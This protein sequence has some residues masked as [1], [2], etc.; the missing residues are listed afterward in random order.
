MAHPKGLL[1]ERAQKLG[2]ER[3]EFD[4]AQTGPEHEPSFL[5]DVTI[6][7]DLL[8]TG[9]GGSK[10]D[11]ERRAAEEALAALAKRDNEGNTTG[12]GGKAAPARAQAQTKESRAARSHAVAAPTPAEAQP[13]GPATNPASE[14]DDAPFQGPWPMVDDVL[15][16]VIQAAERRV[17]ADLRGD[18]ALNAIRDFTLRLYKELLADLG[19]VVDEDD[20][21]D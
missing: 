4:T 18:A 16:A 19:E 1:I 2:L 5:S 17:S 11:A 3:P 20:E 7:G 10:R 9:Q 8:G 6:A 14:D 21:E 13:A 12:K 15:A